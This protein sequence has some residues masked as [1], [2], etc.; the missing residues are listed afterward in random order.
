[1]DNAEYMWYL[2]VA[3]LLRFYLRYTPKE[4]TAFGKQLMS[5]KEEEEGI[6]NTQAALFKN[7]IW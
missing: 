6:N 3:R 1:M 4:L 5:E 7:R 2:L